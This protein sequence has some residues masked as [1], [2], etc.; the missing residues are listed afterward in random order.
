MALSDIRWP[1]LAAAVSANDYFQTALQRRGMLGVT[2]ALQSNRS[3]ILVATDIQRLK[4][5][6]MQG[7]NIDVLL[8]LTGAAAS[9]I[10]CADNGEVGDAD[11]IPVTFDIIAKEF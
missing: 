8:P 3:K 1:E 11:R 4:K 5:S 2:E 10:N 9:A 6:D 7:T